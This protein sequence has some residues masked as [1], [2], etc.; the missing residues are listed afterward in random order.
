M[1][2]GLRQSNRY[3]NLAACLQDLAQPSFHP[4]LG[5]WPGSDSACPNRPD[6]ACAATPRA[7][8][9][10]GW[11]PPASRPGP[12]EPAAHAEEEGPARIL[13]EVRHVLIGVEPLDRRAE[14]VRA[15]DIDRDV[16]GYVVREA[17][18]HFVI[19]IFLDRQVPEIPRLG[20][21][22]ARLVAVRYLRADPV[23]L[24]EQLGIGRERDR[25]RQVGADV[26]G[27]GLGVVVGQVRLQAEA[28]VE[29]ILATDLEA[30]DVG[31]FAVDHL[32]FDKGEC[33]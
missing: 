14:Q 2:S 20:I 27:R 4:S 16:L 18:R 21:Y 3:R 24:V 23:V 6:R 22:E 15:L 13:V 26:P 1:A 17:R 10:A 9:E 30:I 5:T 28:V 29:E 19:R 32:I 7:A 8:I 12:S 33:L 11:L 31:R 25:A